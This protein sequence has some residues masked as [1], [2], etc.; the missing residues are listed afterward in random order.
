MTSF[1]VIT[2]GSSLTSPP[3]KAGSFTALLA[4]YPIL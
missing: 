2:S 3:A 1:P 4:L